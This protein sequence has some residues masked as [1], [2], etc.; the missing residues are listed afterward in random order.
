[1]YI[2]LQIFTYPLILPHL[3][4]MYYVSN[5]ETTIKLLMAPTL[6]YRASKGLPC[7][8][9]I[10]LSFLLEMYYFPLAS[11]CHIA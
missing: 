5:W 2:L 7:I 6:I 3:I 11:N 9:L 4:L 10:N 1:M 8:Q